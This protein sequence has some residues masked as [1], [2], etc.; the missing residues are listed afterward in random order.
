MRTRR[1]VN[2]T[3]KMLNNF[4]SFFINHAIYSFYTCF[5]NASRKSILNERNEDF[6]CI[7]MISPR[8][9]IWSISVRWFEIFLFGNDAAKLLIAIYVNSIGDCER[10]SRILIMLHDG[11]RMVMRTWLSIAWRKLG[12]DWKR[13]WSSSTS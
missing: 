6:N 5:E 12:G 1:Y 2:E 13:L 7:E 4:F 9:K 10:Y 8:A 11:S 3:N